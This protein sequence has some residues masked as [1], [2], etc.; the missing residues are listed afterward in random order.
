LERATGSVPTASLAF[1]R[2]G[3]RYT[4]PRVD[5]AAAL[6]A[7]RAEIDGGALRAVDPDALDSTEA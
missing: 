1:L 2:T 3:E 7:A 6:A 4:P 5:L